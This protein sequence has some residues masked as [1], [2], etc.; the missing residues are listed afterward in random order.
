LT[1]LLNL[2]LMMRLLKLIL[3]LRSLTAYWQP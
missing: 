2:L 3:M 1:L